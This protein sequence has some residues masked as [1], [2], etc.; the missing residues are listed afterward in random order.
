MKPEQQKLRSF[1]A[2]CKRLFGPVESTRSI[3]FGW[4]LS[5][6]ENGAKDEKI[7]HSVKKILLLLRKAVCSSTVSLLIVIV[8]FSWTNH[9]RNTPVSFDR[10]L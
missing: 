10:D 3:R 6:S 7:V 2:L 4:D 1:N 8:V 9:P 5:H